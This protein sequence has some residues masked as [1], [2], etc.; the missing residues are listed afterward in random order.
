M[1]YFLVFAL[2]LF[3]TESLLANDLKLEVSCP[4]SYKKVKKDTLCKLKENCEWK[5]EE[6]G[7]VSSSWR[8]SKG[9]YVRELTFDKKL[10]I[11]LKAEILALSLPWCFKKLTKLPGKNVLSLLRKHKETLYLYP[12]DD[13]TVLPRLKSIKHPCRKLKSME[14]SIESHRFYYLEPQNIKACSKDS[15]NN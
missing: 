8:S 4:T 14:S 2:C 5:I 7:K 9:I 11:E 15:F 13:K 12:K 6:V 3:G 1:N 10:K